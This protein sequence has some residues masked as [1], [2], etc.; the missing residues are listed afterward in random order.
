MALVGSGPA[1][2]L[3]EAIFAEI[4][5]SGDIGDHRLLWRAVAEIGVHR[6]AQILCIVLEQRD[7]AFD[8]VLAQRHG[9]GPVMVVRGTLPAQHVFHLALAVVGHI[10][11]RLIL[12]RCSTRSLPDIHFRTEGPAQA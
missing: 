2:H 3:L 6:L 8:A 11:L 1:V 7:R 10:R 4:H 12:L 5:R 9:F